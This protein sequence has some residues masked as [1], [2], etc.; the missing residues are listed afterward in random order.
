MEYRQANP[1]TLCI[2]D[3]IKSVVEMI[4]RKP[5]WQ[6]HGIEVAGT[7]LDGEE[8]LEMVRRLK[9]DVVLT[10]IRM[11]RM[12]GLEM[13]R[14]IL[15]SNPECRIIILSAYSEFA[16]AQQAIRLGAMDF[17]KKPFSLEEIVNVVL[18]ARDLCLQ[19]REEQE[20]LKAMELKIKASLPILRQEYLTFLMQHQ[21]TESS[22]RARWQYLGIPL[23]P[24]NFVVFIAEIDQ[25]AGKYGAQPVQEIELIRFTLQNILEE[26]VSAWTRGVIFREATNRYVCI[27]NT[28]NYELAEQITEACCA[29]VSRYSR[30]TVSVG[31]GL[32]VPA[33][34]ELA[35]SYTQALRALA[36]HFYT[37]G[38]AVYSYARI[39]HKQRAGGSFTITAEQEFLF[40]LRSG[41]RDK[42]RQVLDRI[43]GELLA[44]DPLPA[45]QYVE[46]IGYELSFKICRVMLEL[47]PYDKV[48]ALEQ[49]VHQLKNRPNPSLQDIRLLL[50]GLCGESCRWIEEDRS[51]ESSRIIH[52]AKA[53]ICA[54]L[55]TSL[56]L[57]QV[58][59]QVNLSQGY[60]S[61]LFKKVLGI[62]FQ[63]FVMHEK[64]EKAKVML[65]EGMQV[66]EIAMELGYEHRRYFSEV[67]KKY[68][69]MTPSEFKISYL[70]KA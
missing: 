53:Y 54:N 60:F 24:E 36:Y 40:A 42:C 10:D 8:G 33:I 37:D 68:T 11:P 70:G 17:V 20:K 41:N 7:A 9:P 52:Q 26:T 29:N 43:F 18:K 45:P 61:N 35:D 2:I 32:C 44:L 27:M 69:D 38:N 4:A 30:Y 25:F 28:D 15:E 62:S 47:F 55:H 16:Y 56:T 22:A 51:A 49:R 63:H 57:E 48:Q 58:A 67:F 6:E 66:Q 21:T 64:M 14:A 46:N 34:H 5:Q 31:V 19:E 23:E 1:V 12:D 50:E 39:A 13:T 59:R 65:I 3:D